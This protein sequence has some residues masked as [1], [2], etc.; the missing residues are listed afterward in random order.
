MTESLQI[1]LV[2]ACVSSD[3]NGLKHAIESGADPD[4]ELDWEKSVDDHTTAFSAVTAS[5]WMSCWRKSLTEF[6]YTF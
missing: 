2:K 6:S 4:L 1:S 5:I 3:L